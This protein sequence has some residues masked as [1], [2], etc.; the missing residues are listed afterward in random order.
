MKKSL[1]LLMIMILISS[2]IYSQNENIPLPV[3]TGNEL[4]SL[5]LKNIDV[6]EVIKILSRKGKLN[7]IIGPNVRGRITMFLNDVNIMTALKSVLE[8]ASLAFIE[9][10]GIYNILPAKEYEVSFG[11]P[12]YNHKNLTIISVKHAFASDIAF[13]L[14]KLK[15]KA[16]II[17][18]ERTNSLLVNDSPQNISDIRKTVSEIDREIITD[19]FEIRHLSQKQTEELIT[20]L[21][22]K[23]GSFYFN[24]MISQV[25][26]KDYPENVKK[27]ITLLKAHDIPA[28]IVTRTYELDYAQFDSIEAKLKLILTPD[29]GSVIADE[30]TNKILVSDLE[31]CFEKIERLISEYDTKD[32]Q[33]LIEA[34]IVQVILNDQFQWGINWQSVISELNGS[35]MGLKLMSAYDMNN[36]LVKGVEFAESVNQLGKVPDLMTQTADTT[37]TT[38]TTSVDE[39][40]KESST[41]NR[42]RTITSTNEVISSENTPFN[43]NISYPTDGGAR[44]IATGTIEGYQ[45]EGV[46]NALKTLGDTKVLSSPRI[47][48]LSNKAAKIEV[49]SKEAYVTSTTLTPGS[50]PS[51]TSENVTFLDVGIILEVTP[52]INQ[53]EF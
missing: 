12:F 38:L 33:V 24:P 2:A 44:I 46:L 3:N 31:F 42:I 37:T 27:I 1:S 43:T 6:I 47:I 15:P 49:A 34:K 28:Q 29:V 41:S 51:S 9:Q 26:I 45:F 35:N 8:S 53:N 30:R 11:R 18:D 25:V 39:D 5:E 23:K 19:N 20:L 32:R 21:L 7:V 52:V 16:I 50:G 17:V 40:G 36:D 10:D 48:T 14:A 4:V 22:G 13:S